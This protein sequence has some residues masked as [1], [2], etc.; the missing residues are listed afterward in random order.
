MLINKR[1]LSKEEIGNILSY[2]MRDTDRIIIGVYNNIVSTVSITDGDT[3]LNISIERIS[4]MS[5]TD[6]GLTSKVKRYLSSLEVSNRV[7]SLASADMMLRS[8]NAE[9]DADLSEALRY[10]ASEAT[11]VINHHTVLSKLLAEYEAKE[12]G[13]QTCDETNSELIISLRDTYQY[14]IDHNEIS[15][16]LA[17]HLDSSINKYGDEFVNA[18][19][20]AFYRAKG[21]LSRQ[22]IEDNKYSD[23]VLLH[24]LTLL[25]MPSV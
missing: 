22:P 16:A 12:M 14:N 2:Q 6:I 7:T 25:S 21:D 1:E 24:V 15:K 20:D 3:V 4:E 17:I 8:E 5:M 23:V 11:R 18:L 9:I 10:Q 19:S 13:K